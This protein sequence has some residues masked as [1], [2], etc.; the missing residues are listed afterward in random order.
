M[1]E[2]RGPTQHQDLIIWDMPNPAKPMRTRIPPK[3][4]SFWSVVL[5]AE[6]VD[7]ACSLDNVVAA[8]AVSAKLWAVLPG[9]YINAA[10]ASQCPT[11]WTCCP[12]RHCPF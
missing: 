9:A 4:N 8:V 11:W 1:L 7:L 3:T 12:L 6:L 5:T 2:C 10:A